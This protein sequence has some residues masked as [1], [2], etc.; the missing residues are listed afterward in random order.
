MIYK[1]PTQRPVNCQ[2]D[3]A[4]HRQEKEERRA[5]PTEQTV[6]R[7]LDTKTRSFSSCLEVVHSGLVINNDQSID[8]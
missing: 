7:L 5:K 8:H 2:S 1:Y 4:A 3:R 6:P